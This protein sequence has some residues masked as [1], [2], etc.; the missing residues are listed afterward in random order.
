[1][2]KVTARNL[3]CSVLYESH[4][5]LQSTNEKGISHIFKNSHKTRRSEVN[6]RPNITYQLVWLKTN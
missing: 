3:R 1:M 2:Q 6:V 4:Q 5:V